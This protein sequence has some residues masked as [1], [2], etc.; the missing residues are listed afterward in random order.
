[1]PAKSLLNLLL[2]CLPLGLFAQVDTLPT[3]WHRNN[4]PGPN[5]N[6]VSLSLQV[7]DMRG[8]PVKNL[9]LWLKQEDA[10]VA[11]YATTDDNG[12]VYLLLP[13]GRRFAVS[14][15]DEEAFESIKTI[16][17]ANVQSRLT[18]GYSPKTYEEHITADT[19]FQVVPPDQM[20]THSR[21]LLRLT[22]TDYEENPHHEEKLFFTIKNRKEVYV[23]STNKAGV[24]L[25]MLPKGDSLYMH[26]Q[27]E[28]NIADFYF[29]DD[30]RAGTLRLRY[31]TIGSKAILAREAERKRQA[32]IRDS[33]AELARIRDSLDF[34]KGAADGRSL[35]GMYRWGASYEQVEATLEETAAK[36]RDA[37][38]KDEQ[39]FMKAGQEINA[40]MYRHR[41][42]WADKVIV[43][44]V[45]GSMYPYMDQLLLWHALAILPGEHNR[46][47]FFNDGDGK[48]TE[49]KIIGQTGGIYSCEERD[50]KAIMEVMKTTMQ[51]GGGGETP[52]NDIESLLAATRLIGEGDEL[53]LIADN[54]SDVRDLE[55][56]ERLRIPVRIV[57]AGVDQWINEDYLHLAYMTGG[58]IHTIEEDLFHLTNLNDGEI[59]TIGNYKY[60][61][62]RGTFILLKDF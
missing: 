43:S 23:A 34:L 3:P 31:R 62:N 45:T 11:Y 60:R 1:M 2:I 42:L 20:P 12:K 52:E 28:K 15:T 9:E 38:E 25:L 16:N 61:V 47:L 59:V 32:A 6:E 19:V 49:E 58:S 22:V 7:V 46:Y 10:A 13:R 57:L 41:E 51:A 33:L 8:E 50:I 17:R 48:A 56:L 27:F 14:S 36:T 30:K 54:Y 5:E 26:T 37:L 29:P 24:A 18:I 35:M 21:V 40:A 55:L 4:V 39:Y 44:D 53:I